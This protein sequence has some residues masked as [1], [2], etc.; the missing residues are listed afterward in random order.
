MAKKKTTQGAAAN[1]NGKVME[2]AILSA[3]EEHGFRVFRYVE[4]RDKPSKVDG[5]DRYVLKNV[6]YT[7]IYGS[8]RCR[9]EYV[10][11]Y[12]DRAIRV[13]CKWQSSSGSVDEKFPYLWRNAVEQYPESEIILLVDGDGY[14]EC[15]RNWLQTMIA[16]NDGDYE[17]RGKDIELMTLT[18]F[19]KW[20]N[21]EF[22]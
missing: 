5:L 19:L 8:S 2:K 9:T 18:E 1:R 14:R 15:A 6:P 21:E 22:D 17:S 10:I 12:E 3:F 11:H 20:F 4:V 13:E 7:S 16:E